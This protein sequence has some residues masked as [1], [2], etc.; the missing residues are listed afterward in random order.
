[1]NKNFF[2]VIT[3]FLLL[4]CAAFKPASQSDFRV[5]VQGSEHKNIILEGLKPQEMTFLTIHA[6]DS[7]ME[8][9]EFELLLARGQ[10]PV[11]MPGM[12]VSGN[13][14]GLEKLR[15][16]AKTGDRLVVKVRKVKSQADLEEKIVTI[17]IK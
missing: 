10:S 5:V 17:P 13:H 4:A 7:N 6:M 11:G 9:T 1:M 3:L 12:I 16:F 2:Q 14:V 15:P 8:V